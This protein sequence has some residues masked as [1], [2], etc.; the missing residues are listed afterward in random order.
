MRSKGHSVSVIL[1]EYGVTDYIRLRTDIIVRLP[2]KEEAR[3]LAQP[4]T[5]PVM[6]TKKVD[7]D[8]KGT[9]ISYSETVWAS[10][11]MQFSI[12]NT[13]QLLSVLAQ[14]ENGEGEGLGY[15]SRMKSARVWLGWRAAANNVGVRPETDLVRDCRPHAR[16][17]PFLVRVRQL[18][19][20]GRPF[21]QR[22]QAAV[23]LLP[24]HRLIHLAAGSKHGVC[25]L[26]S[27]SREVVERHP[28]IVRHRHHQ[29]LT[30]LCPPFVDLKIKPDDEM[31]ALAA[32]VRIA[33]LDAV[34]ACCGDSHAGTSSIELRM[35]PEVRRD[36]EGSVTVAAMVKH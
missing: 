22:R 23:E 21:G 28:R 9:P 12:D 35:P 25:L 36:Q 11:R 30:G 5:E 10:E 18:L 3:R 24:P 8:M 14:A 7:V 4:E 27:L 2:T 33:D 1:A 15:A 29:F 32:R 31:R 17:H 6:L 13:S 20:A 16:Q 26:E 34:D 19:G